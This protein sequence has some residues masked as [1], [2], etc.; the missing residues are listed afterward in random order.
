M[1][2]SLQAKL[3]FG[4]RLGSEV[5]DQSGLKLGSGHSPS[6]HRFSAALKAQKVRIW[7]QNVLM[8]NQSDGSETSL[9]SWGTPSPT[10]LKEMLGELKCK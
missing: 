10:K 6:Q 9:S 8:V 1:D 2:P 5:D 3:G 4:L 7:G